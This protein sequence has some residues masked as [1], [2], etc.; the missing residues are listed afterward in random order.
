M[1]Q[2]NNVKNFFRLVAEDK[3]PSGIKIQVLRVF[4]RGMSF[5]YG[6]GVFAVR[7]LYERGILPRKRLPFPV[8]SVG[9]L[10]W[11]GTGKTPL[12]EYLAQR[13]IERHKTPLIL[14]RGY[15]KDETEQYR[16][17]L[18]GAR[19][20]VGKERYEVAQ[21]MRSRDRIDLSILDDGFQH[22]KVIRDFDI[23]TV[24]A[25]NPFGNEKLFPR[26][27][28]REPPQ[29]LKR[30]NVIVLSHVNLPGAKELEALRTR[31]RKLAPK[32]FL[33]EAYLEPLFLY[34]PRK[35]IRLSL[36]QLQHQRVAT[37]SAVASPRSFQ[38]LLARHGVK[39]VRNFEFCD[40]HRFSREE[41]DEIVQI[42]KKGEV[43][44]ILTT[45]KDFYRSPELISQI[46][47]PLILAV[48][49]RIASGEEILT[50]R[51]FRLLGVR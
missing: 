45:E 39:A 2:A 36:P 31:I 38:L 21:K 43:D 42:S 27:I 22:W 6:M 10:T 37:F 15:G 20:G 26:G 50:D 33:V 3:Q 44:E 46:I 35:R 7:W 25:L 17:H 51:I 5:F 49:L 28:L 29:S 13:V 23:V 9:N 32:A 18:P 40:H 4:L 34:R 12:V 16:A 1:K 8:I 11:G 24:N 41:L 48:R 14:T 19:I 30:A 47:D